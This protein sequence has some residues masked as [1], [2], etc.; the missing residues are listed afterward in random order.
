MR[1]GQGGGGVGGSGSVGAGGNSGDGA[2]TTGG[3]VAT[4]GGAA[5]ATQQMTALE[6]AAKT[7]NDALAQDMKYPELDNYM[8][9]EFRPGTLHGPFPLR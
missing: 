6:R 7:I 4:T 5:P 9:R 2:A 1:L 3:T 8:T